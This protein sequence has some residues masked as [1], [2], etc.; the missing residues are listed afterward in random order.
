MH[1]SVI[2]PCHNAEAYVGEALR[3]V[4]A[5]THPA[6]EVIV[7][8]DR[9]TDGSV[10]AIEASGVPVTLLHTDFGNA[11]AARNEIGRAHV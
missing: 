10:A 11:A 5:Q 7:I 1:F 9:S 4:A 2:M 3:S 6:H 8:N